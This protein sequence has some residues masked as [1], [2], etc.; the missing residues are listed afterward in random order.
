[1]RSTS[2]VPCQ[3]IRG[4][5]VSPAATRRDAEPRHASYVEDH[6]LHHEAAEVARRV[7]AGNTESPRMTWQGTLEVLRTLDEVRAQ[8]GV[9]YPGE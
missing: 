2:R 1:M 4:L 7:A 3:V 9:R 6:G 5:S 8:V